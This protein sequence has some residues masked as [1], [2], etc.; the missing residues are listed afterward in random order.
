MSVK[1]SVVIPT[2]RRPEL[3]LKCLRALITQRLNPGLFEIIIVTD[4]PDELTAQLYKKWVR[5]RLHRVSLYSLPEKKGPAAARNYG[6]LV[7]K[8]ELNCFYR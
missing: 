7:A 5:R 2:Y 6:W 4:G 1:I 3:L 8:G